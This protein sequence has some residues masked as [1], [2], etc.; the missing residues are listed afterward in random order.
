MESKCR[1]LNRESA[2]DAKV[3]D[4]GQFRIHLFQASQR[5]I[6]REDGYL[7]WHCHVFG[8]IDRHATHTVAPLARVVTTGVIDQDPA[9]DL[10]RDTKKMR[11]ILPI[12]L[13]LVDEADV[14]LVNKGARLQGVVGPLV[15][16]LARGHAPELRIDKWQQLVKG[17][18]I[19]ATPI[20]E[21]RRDVAR[22][23]WILLPVGSGA[24]G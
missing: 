20:A 2:K 19:A 14:R 1:F 7:V 10:R 3:N 12:D 13:A 23:Y 6:Q 8:F 9:H 15:P 17:S 24:S 5:V 21:Q 16:K 18:L 11:S 4:L 22:A